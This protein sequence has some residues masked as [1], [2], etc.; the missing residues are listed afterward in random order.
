MNSISNQSEPVAKFAGVSNGMCFVEALDKGDVWPLGMPFYT[1]PIHKEQEWGHLSN[2]EIR[3]IGQNYVNNKGKIKFWL[4][5][6]RA[7]EAKIMEKNNV[8]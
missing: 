5:F 2:A 4:E 6:A 8:E 3:R 1:T 7:I